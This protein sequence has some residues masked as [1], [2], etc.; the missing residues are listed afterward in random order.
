MKRQFSSASGAIL[1]V[2]AQG[3]SDGLSVAIEPVAIDGEDAPALQVQAAIRRG[4]AG[5]LLVEIDGIVRTVE[6]TVV[7]EQVWL[8]SMGNTRPGGTTVRYTRHEVRR[9]GS[10]QAAGGPNAPVVCPMT[11]RVV[12][13]H[14]QPGD[15]VKKGQAVV[16]VEAMK[17]E[18]QLRAPRDGVVAQVHCTVG[19]L[20]DGGV[21]LVALEPVAEDP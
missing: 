10:G 4:P 17:M 21:A 8:S 9:G 1:D 6:A 2:Q 18:H 20:I 19:D 11:G 14:V 13:V 15:A 7:K 12:V 3:N 5:Q 16:V